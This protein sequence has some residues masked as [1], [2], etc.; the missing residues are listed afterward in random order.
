MIPVRAARARRP[1]V[2][3]TDRLRT[4]ARFACAPDIV[5]SSLRI[6]LVVG[7]VVNLINQGSHWFAGDGL[8]LGHLLLNYMVP[9]C[10]AAYSAV[11]T[12][13]QDCPLQE[14]PTGS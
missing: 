3:D 5:R 14:N 4:A 2:I 7:T 11:H 6:A 12:R 1:A 9:Y 10:V 13:L 8:L